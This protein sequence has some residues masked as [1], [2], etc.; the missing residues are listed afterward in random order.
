M[1]ARSASSNVI[2]VPSGA[3]RPSAISI[4]STGAITPEIHGD[5]SVPK[6]IFTPAPNKARHGNRFF[7]AGCPASVRRSSCA[8]SGGCQLATAPAWA[9]RGIASAGMSCACSTRKRGVAQIP[10]PPD[11]LEHPQQRAQLVV[12]AGMHHHLQARLRRARD[13]AVIPFRRNHAV[14]LYAAPVQPIV[15]ATICCDVIPQSLPAG[16]R[17]RRVHAKAQPAGH[18]ANAAR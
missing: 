9:I 8:S 14:S 11:T 15:A 10:L 12:R 13:P 5:E 7:G 2:R 18:G 17:G 3:A 16:Q 1:N 4:A 6:A